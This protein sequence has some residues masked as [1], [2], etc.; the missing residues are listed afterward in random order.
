LQIVELSLPSSLQP[1]ID[2]DLHQRLSH[3]H[4]QITQQYKQEIIAIL[5]DTIETKLHESQLLFH[6]DIT[7]IW[8]NQCISPIDQQFNET[9]L[10][11]IQHHLLIITEKIQYT[12][13][14][15]KY[16][17]ESCINYSF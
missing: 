13:H 1:L 15:K 6:N 14:Y 9:M 11:L 16:Y 3:D 5:I 2:I 10:D 12:Y 4:R 7:K 17:Y 8:Q